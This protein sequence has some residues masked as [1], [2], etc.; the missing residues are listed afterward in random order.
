MEDKIQELADNLTS[1]IMSYVY[2]ER[3]DNAD[4]I[5]EDE[6]LNKAWE[7]INE[8]CFGQL[9]ESYDQGSADAYE[10]MEEHD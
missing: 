1:S 10:D 6:E 7:Y 3:F 4:D 2:G 9:W 8:E 5:T